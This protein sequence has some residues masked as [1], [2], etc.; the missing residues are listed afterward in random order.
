MRSGLV[1]VLCGSEADRLYAVNS[2]SPACVSRKDC[3]ASRGGQLHLGQLVTLVFM[4]PRAE[5]SPAICGVLTSCLRLRLAVTHVLACLQK[6]KA[7]GLINSRFAPAVVRT[8][9]QCVVLLW[10]CAL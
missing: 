7:H 10:F 9:V 1:L 2:P 4:C 3:A 6:H 5:S 8:V